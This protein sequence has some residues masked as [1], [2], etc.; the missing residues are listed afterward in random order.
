MILYYSACGNSRLIAE[1]LAESLNEKLVFIPQAS[2][3]N[4]FEYELSEGEA[5]GFVWPV[6]CWA[7]PQ[8]VMDYVSRLKF[9]SK[10]AYVYLVMTCGD[11]TGLAPDIF[12][13]E[14]QK[15]NLE[16][17]SV[18]CMIMPETYINIKSMYLDSAEKAKAKTENSLSRLPEIAEIISRRENTDTFIPVG[19]SPWLKSR[20]VKPIFYAFLVKDKYFSVNDL[21]I[22]CGKCAEVCPLENIELRDGR[23][24]WKGHCTTCNACYHNC[25]VNA[26]HFGKATEGKGQFRLPNV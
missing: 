21:C 20:I 6:Y 4:I 7:P 18:H 15:I 26:I 25:P 3:D 19:D 13:K 22:S 11:T 23:P 1:R 17:N 12:R 9:R 16:L 24:H 14:L 8:L 10:P 2:R 5:L